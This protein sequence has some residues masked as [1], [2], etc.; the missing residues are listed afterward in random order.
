MAWVAVVAVCTMAVRF[1]SADSASAAVGQ[2]VE[3]MGES[4][5]IRLA[6]PQS[7]LHIGAKVSILSRSGRV[8]VAEGVLATG[9]GLAWQVDLRA[10]RGT[11]DVEVGCPVRILLEATPA[12]ASTRR[13]TARSQDVPPRAAGEEPLQGRPGSDSGFRAARESEE[14]LRLNAGSLDGWEWFVPGWGFDGGAYQATNGT[15]NVR[16]ELV[17]RAGYS[18]RDY[19]LSASVRMEDRYA[20]SSALLIFRYQNEKEYGGCQ[21]LQDYSGTRLELVD[22]HQGL[23]KAVP[24]PARVGQSYRIRASI[25]GTR[26]E[27]AVE[28]HPETA[29]EAEF[30]G[31]AS[32]TIGL[33]NA[34]IA[35]AFDHLEV[36]GIGTI[37]SAA[38]AQLSCAP[39]RLKLGDAITLSM[40][41]PHG[42]Q[43]LVSDPAGTQFFVAHYYTAD[44]APSIISQEQFEEL[45]EMTI[46]TGVAVATPWVHGRSNSYERIFTMPGVYSFSIG[47]NLETD[48][49]E[50][51]RQTRRCKVEIIS[52]ADASVSFGPRALKLA[53]SKLAQTEYAPI[54]R[55]AIEGVSVFRYVYGAAEF[56]FLG[57]PTLTLSL[58]D[59]GPVGVG[60]TILWTAVEEMIK[61]AC[62]D[63]EKASR[64]IAKTTYDLGLDAYREN[65]GLYQQYKKTG[66]LTEDDAKRF[67]VN[68]YIQGYMSAAKQLYNDTTVYEKKDV[69]RNPDELLLQ[70][71]EATASATAKDAFGDLGE[72]EVRYFLTTTKGEFTFLDLIVKSSAGLGAYPPYQTFLK[73]I[74]KIDTDLAAAVGNPAMAATNGT[75]SSESV[76]DT[77]STV[78]FAR[79]WNAAIA[80]RDTA[81][82]SKLFDN[83]FL[84]WNS[85]GTRS[86]RGTILSDPAKIAAIAQ[87]FLSDEVTIGMTGQIEDDGSPQFKE[88]LGG[89]MSRFARISLGGGNYVIGIGLTKTGWRVYDIYDP[90]SRPIPERNDAAVL[91]PRQMPRGWYSQCFAPACCP[92]SS[93]KTPEVV[94]GIR[95]HKE[96]QHAG[97][98]G[99]YCVQAEREKQNLGEGSVYEGHFHFTDAQ[100]WAPLFWKVPAQCSEATQ[101]L[102][103]PFQDQESQMRFRI[104]G[105]DENRNWICTGSV[106]LER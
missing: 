84:H 12:P 22:A 89:R 95:N 94:E 26:A 10:T 5:M 99:A 72:R 47:R 37:P 16:T 19:T 9:E 76:P 29:I 77:K 75:S 67:V 25:A 62:N 58:V 96:F 106:L 38:R 81:N 11:E 23:L 21:F 27:C 65:Y 48:D 57:A 60:K 100:P 93:A 105:G 54:T 101:V 14:S 80:K 40:P 44:S 71:L 64:K 88:Q 78:S 15:P 69:L 102:V 59:G 82:F 63:P 20:P 55:A 33:R 51:M 36:A 74:R 50:D 28:G 3:V 79:T 31:P 53:S 61:E 35:V 91:A 83:R 24:F 2:V 13:G 18:W 6:E 90:Q 49:A 39:D 43:M 45:G 30:N 42:A 41:R 7:A 73:S 68:S 34:H 1:V 8:I 66:T 70:Q 97:G 4:V 86:D 87:G 46:F 98:L 85:Y 92:P 103:G 56:I 17:W 32:G 104:S 52:P